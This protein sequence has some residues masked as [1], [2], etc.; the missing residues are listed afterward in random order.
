M[1][2]NTIIFH[3]LTFRRINDI[4]LQYFKAKLSIWNIGKS[5]GSEDDELLHAIRRINKN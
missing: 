2:S 4:E 3:S 5:A 1:K